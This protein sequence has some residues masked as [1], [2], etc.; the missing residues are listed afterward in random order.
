MV[1]V[2]NSTPMR[3]PICGG[4]LV[5]VQVRDI[6]DVT[7]HLL[8]QMHSG[9]CTEHG[10]FQAELISKPPREIFPV[11]RPGGS[12]RHVVVNGVSIYAFPTVW[13]TLESRQKV[14]PLD[15]KYWE[16]DWGQINVESSITS[17]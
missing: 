9:R 17:D 6:G 15:P 11:D 16:V 2:Q 12:A 8:W 14:D 1:A 3:C 10:W 5:D 7:A 13:T 4:E